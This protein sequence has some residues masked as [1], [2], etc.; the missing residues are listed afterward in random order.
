[1]GK[2]NSGKEAWDRGVIDACEEYK[3]RMVLKQIF[4]LVFFVHR[5]IVDFSSFFNVGLFCE[6]KY[7]TISSI[8][9]NPL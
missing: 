9:T 6:A 2:V 1:L 3:H 5:N 8:Y 4:F 7:L